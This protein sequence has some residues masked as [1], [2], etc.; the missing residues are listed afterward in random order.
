[1]HFCGDKRPKL[2]EKHPSATVGDLAKKLGAAWKVM[3]EE[4][5]RP[6]EELAR[7]DRDRYDDEM[8]AWRERK[9]V[10]AAANDDDED[11]EEEEEEEEEEDQSSD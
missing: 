10:A 5:K 3:N 8:Q 6:Y 11:E 4:Q 7:K 1:M 9:G 2:R